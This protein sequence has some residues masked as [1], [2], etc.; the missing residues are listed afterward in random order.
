MTPPKQLSKIEQSPHFQ[1]IVE[2]YRER[3][4]KLSKKEIF[5]THITP[6]D[7]SLRYHQFIRLTVK[8]DE[9]VAA[10]SS[11]VIATY[12]DGSVNTAKMRQEL[13]LKALQL[14]DQS[15]TSTLE[16]WGKQPEKITSKQLRD[17]FR[18]YKE[19]EQVRQN[20][21]VIDLK[22][23]EQ[24]FEEKFKPAGMYAHLWIQLFRQSTAGIIQPAELQ[25]L[26]DAVA[27]IEAMRNGNK[28]L[29]ELDDRFDYKS[30][31]TEVIPAAN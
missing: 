30:Q 18:M 15:L 4:D 14:G 24:E 21:E 2:L 1:R 26:Q 11:K 9:S 13:Y 31:V 19:M 3:K 8:L 12:I 7:P 6:L 20:D 10:E 25:I 22:K 28:L 29:T 16:L 5:N 23:K 27:K 17:F